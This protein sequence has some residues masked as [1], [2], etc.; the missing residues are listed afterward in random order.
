VE[1]L[2]KFL[3]VREVAPSHAEANPAE[4]MKSR[5]ITI[6]VLQSGKQV[7]ESVELRMVASSCPVDHTFRFFEPQNSHATLLLPPFVALSSPGLN[8]IVSRPNA[9]CTIEPTNIRIE[10]K[11]ESAPE[12]VEFT[13]FLYGDQFK[14]KLLACC[15]VEL[16]SLV[17]VYTRIRA[18]V[19]LTQ[20][21]SLPADIARTVRLYSSNPKAVYL[22]SKNVERTYKL[23]PSSMNPLQVV[24]KTCQ[25]EQIKAKVNCVDINSG[26]LV[27]AWL[28]LIDSE[29]PHVTK[30]QE[31]DLKVNTG[32]V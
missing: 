4:Y 10:T 21:L 13:L 27:Y 24:A 15:K 32:C 30:V 29:K 19:A 8:A 3:S 28:L 25:R 5:P 6:V 22:P 11:T 31:V 18:G 12:V 16:Y 2:F 20:T 7:H 14:E 23:V 26:E 17:A 9:T 1:L